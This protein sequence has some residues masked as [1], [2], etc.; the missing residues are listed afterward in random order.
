[1]EPLHFCAKTATKK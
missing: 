1:M